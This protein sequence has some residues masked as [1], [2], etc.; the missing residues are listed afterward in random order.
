MQK[1][2]WDESLSVGIEEYERLETVML[3]GLEQ[4]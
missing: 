3:K 2:V 1:I 4:I